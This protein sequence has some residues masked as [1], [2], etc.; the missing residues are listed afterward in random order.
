MGEQY[1][2][3]MRR[4]R[5]EGFSPRQFRAICW[6]ALVLLGIIVVTG[7]LVRLTGSGLGCNDWPN[8]NNSQFVDLST[9]HSA[10]EQINRFFTFLVCVGVALA[11]LAA[12]WRRPRRRDLLVL[13]LVM[14]LGVPA[15][16]VVGA[17]VVWTK[18]HPG[19]VMLHFVLSM[20]L[21]WTAVV[22]LVRSQESDTGQRQ[23]VVT[24]RAK[25]LVGVVIACTALAVFAGT[26]TTG[27]GPHAGDEKAKRWFG[28]QQH[29]DGHAVQWVARVHSGLVWVAVAA[30]LA[31]FLA[32]RHSASDRKA[33][34]R[35]LTLW[36]TVAVAQGCIG[37]VQY[38]SGLPSALV[39]VHLAGATTL[40]G[41]TAWLW[42][43][44]RQR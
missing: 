11:A 25:R 26:I 43:S 39:A 1:P 23:L 20:V 18:V 4:F 13:S 5:A 44:M 31:L 33:L 9:R 38:A 32:V 40:V 24:P 37:Y 10:I 36:A 15:Q 14:L 29:I 34:E 6:F 27:T 21:V 16:G 30:V 7:G 35:P 12:W 17:I 19:A 28:T 3:G 41:A 2:C 42:C 8:C 22:M